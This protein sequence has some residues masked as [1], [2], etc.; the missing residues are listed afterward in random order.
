MDDENEKRE[1]LLQCCD[2]IIS[3][4]EYITS[5][6]R[7]CRS[8]VMRAENKE[9]METGALSIFTNVLAKGL[10][11]F[12]SHSQ[13]YMENLKRKYIF[14]GLSTYDTVLQHIKIDKANKRKIEEP[15]QHTAKER[16]IKQ[17]NI[18]AEKSDVS[19]KPMTGEIIVIEDDL[20]NGG[21]E[22]VDKQ[23]TPTNIS[24]EGPLNHENVTTEV[25]DTSIEI[26]QAPADEIIAIVHDSPNEECISENVELIT[27][28]GVGK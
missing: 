10:S 24:K 5:V 7:L 9:A 12:C 25:C 3:S 14:N 11:M 28:E 1:I 27:E 21:I 20:P 23:D 16:P 17:E 13:L 4:T 22:T 15:I 2:M 19:M 6:T 8:E 18:T 26:V